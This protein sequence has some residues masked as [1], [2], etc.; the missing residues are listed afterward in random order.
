MTRATGSIHYRDYA[1][2]EPLQR[3][4]A[5][6]LH[7]QPR[8]GR[9]IIIGAFVNNVSVIACELNRNRFDFRCVKQNRPPIYQ[10]FDVPGARKRHAEL[11]EAAKQ[12]KAA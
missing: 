11:L 5:F 3:V 6:M 12:K 2:S 7:G 10:L 9:E 8:T 1:G 4:I